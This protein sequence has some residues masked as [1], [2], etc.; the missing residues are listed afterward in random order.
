MSGTNQPKKEW[1]E[2]IIHKFCR[3]G[4]NALGPPFQEPAWGTPL[5]GYARGDDPCFERLK[6]DIGPFYWTPLDAFRRCFPQV[7]TTAED[8]AVISYALPQTP[9]TRKNQRTASRFPA[10]RW[11]HSR[12]YGEEF[13]CLLRCHLAKTLSDAG[14]PAIAPERLDEF[15]YRESP[16]FGL[17]SNWSERHTA[18]IAGLGTFGLSDGLITRAGKAVRFGSVVTKMNL[19]PSKRPYRGH[20]DWCLWYVNGTCGVCMKRCPINAI[21]KSG[22]DKL[23]CHN[24]I[25]QVTVPYVQQHYGT[26]TTPCGLC[27]VKI[28]CEDR[29]PSPRQESI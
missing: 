2:S 15:G 14:F 25:R 7:E 13:N 27:Q 23:S 28:P 6:K 21:R 8:L 9:A 24:Y 1:I 10:R 20:Q 26:D 22:H 11:A 17:A 19:S 3:S 16:R 4:Q 18:W 5:V 29:L 12:F